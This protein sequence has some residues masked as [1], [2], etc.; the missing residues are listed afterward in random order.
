MTNQ[1]IENLKR[2]LLNEK[3]NS[4]TGKN[5]IKGLDDLVTQ[6]N[7][8]ISNLRSTESLQNKNIQDLQSKIESGTKQA[9][10]EMSQSYKEYAEK[11]LKQEKDLWLEKLKCGFIYLALVS[12]LTIVIFFFT[13]ISLSKKIALL[14]LDVIAGSWLWFCSFQYSYFRELYRDYK[15]REVV[16]SSFIGFINNITNDNNLK[17]EAAKVIVGTLFTGVKPEKNN[18]LPLKEILEITKVAISKL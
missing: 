3:N 2:D 12:L 4:D 14:S 1:E 11:I 8:Q 6:L 9:I 13:E 15:N 16:A 5:R 18:D 7:L 17:N 10:Q